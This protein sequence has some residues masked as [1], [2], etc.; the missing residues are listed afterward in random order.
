MK[1][2]D[3]LME[4]DLHPDTVAFLVY[5]FDDMLKHGNLGGQDFEDIANLLNLL[6]NIGKGTIHVNL[7]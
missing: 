6:T 3:S 4:I 5:E 7:V 2:K 1:I